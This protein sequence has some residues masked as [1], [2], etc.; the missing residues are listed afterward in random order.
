MTHP[1]V[2]PILELATPLAQRLGLEVVSAVFQTNK[3]PPV[4]R[5]DIRNPQGDTGLD[6]CEAL[7]RQLEA[8]LEATA[9]IPHAYVLEVSSPGLSPILTAERDFLSFKGFKV[10]VD[11]TEDYQGR[12]R[13]E[14]TLQGRDET[15]LHLQVKG[16]AI[17]LPRQ[18]ITLVRLAD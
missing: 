11:L 15:H 10:A 8:E 18:L 2:P 9:L 16:R 1:L 12:Q 7:S 6:D 14:G 4:L 5:L 13:W 3:T 17:A